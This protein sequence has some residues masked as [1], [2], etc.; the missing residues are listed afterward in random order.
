MRVV[1]LD[2][3][4]LVW[5]IRRQATPN[6]TEMIPRAE[7]LIAGLEADRA[8]RRAFVVIPVPALGEFLIHE[9]ESRHDA[10]TAELRRRFHLAP[11]DLPAASIAARIW[12]QAQACGAYPEL[13]AD[14][15]TRQIIKVDTQIL[16]V[17][18]AQG[19]TVL[20]TE[21]PGRRTLAGRVPIVSARLD[22]V[23]IPTPEK[24]LGL[25]E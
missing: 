24:Q 25:F 4:V 12:Q 10:V 2:C 11:Y 15:V 16:A 22:A 6:R 14:G 20:Y 13:I 18:L 23:P 7:A 9:D 19:A 8:A 1:A 5:G 3:Q 17:A 21:D